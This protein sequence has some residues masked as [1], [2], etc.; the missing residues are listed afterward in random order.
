VSIEIPSDSTT[1][2]DL[3]LNLSSKTTNFPFFPPHIHILDTSKLDLPNAS[4]VIPVSYLGEQTE[5]DGNS[6]VD[7]DLH[8]SPNLT[9]VAIVHHIVS[10]FCPFFWINLAHT[11]PLFCIGSKVARMCSTK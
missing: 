9:L 11:Y 4:D 2:I 1:L 3:F 5:N 10:N 7:L 6:M 8:W